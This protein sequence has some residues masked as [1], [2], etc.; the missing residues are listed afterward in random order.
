MVSARSG[1]DVYRSLSEQIAAAERRTA[2]AAEDVRRLQREDEA[3]RQAETR[4]LAELARVRL[5]ELDGERVAG[6][7]DAADRQAMELLDRRDGERARLDEEIGRSS[8]RLA[9]LNDER[10]QRLQARDEAAAQH[11]RLVEATL[12]RLEQDADY[13]AQRGHVEHLTAQAQHAARKAD[14]AEADRETKRRP[15][16][17]DKLFAYL[18]RRRYRFPEYRA[19]PLFR[20]LDGWVARLCGYDRAHRDYAMLL[21][22]PVRLRAHADGVAA[23]AAAAAAELQR[24]EQEALERDGEPALRAVL[25][26]RQDELDET[27][28]QL[29]AAEDAHSALLQGRGRFDA[30]ADEAT[31]EALQALTA[32]LASEDVA[33]LRRDARQTA[34]PHD[35]EL[36]DRVAGQRAR[37]REIASGL[38]AAREAEAEAQ[39]G[40]NELLELRR[41]FRHQGFDDESSVFG[42]DLD[43]GEL[44][45]GV[46]RGVLHAGTAFGR[47]RGH[48]RWRRPRVHTGSAVAGRILGSLLSGAGRRGGGFGGFGGGG[49]FRSGGGFGGGGFRTGGGF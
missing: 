19:A 47:L 43:L 27:D 20:T 14:Q 40:V 3:A 31:Q 45:G 46:L 6:G 5:A 29:D 13:A 48:H 38:Q 37:Q 39:H 41:R 1:K 35:D 10:A 7:L 8:G 26:E 42:G 30:G 11:R 21:E 9:A 23:R 32:Q 12:Q 25:A 16:E 49:G 24:L 28:R 18:W 33:T 2:A 34:A 22:I 17:Q 4:A 36:A 15:Y 44:I